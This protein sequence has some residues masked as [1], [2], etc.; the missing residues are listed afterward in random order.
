MFF[1]A[2]LVLRKA[3]MPQT[4][5]MMQSS[6]LRFSTSQHVN[7]TSE[8]VPMPT[9]TINKRQELSEAE[10]LKQNLESSKVTEFP[11]CYFP[12]AYE[13]PEN[14]IA[15]ARKNNIRY[16]AHKLAAVANCIHGKHVGD[17]LVTLGNIDKKGADVIHSVVR[18]ARHNGMK[19]GM[20]EERMFIKYAIVGKGLMHKK[21]DIKGRGK[22]GIIRVPKSS[23]RIE[24]EEKSAAD[25]YK[26]CL[27]GEAPPAVGHIF[28]RILY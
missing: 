25:F 4:I 20:S 23:F 12:D 21:M 22:H 8:R 14:R 10:L 11:E 28:R 1:R 17:A 26:M 3:T 13:K 9:I 16:S 7:T 19:Q 15:K 18:A 27:K 5:M 24:V 6:L 2:P